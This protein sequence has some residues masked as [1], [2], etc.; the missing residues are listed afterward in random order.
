MVLAKIEPSIASIL[1]AKNIPF[2]LKSVDLEAQLAALN[3]PLAS[4]GRID[5]GLVKNHACLS[6]SNDGHAVRAL[7]DL[8]NK[9]KLKGTVTVTWSN[10]IMFSM[11]IDAS[12]VVEYSKQIL[13]EDWDLWII[14]ENS[15]WVIEKYHEG[16]ICY[17]EVL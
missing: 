13:A 16:E 9:N 7:I 2:V 10:G 6:F 5:W 3:L 11:T 1:N 12:I 8:F 15:G 17:T 14:P 4:Y